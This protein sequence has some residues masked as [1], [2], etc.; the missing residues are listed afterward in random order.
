VY[1]TNPPKGRPDMTEDSISKTKTTPSRNAKS[2]STRAR[3][4]VKTDRRGAGE[5]EHPALDDALRYAKEGH[6]VFPLL[7]I[8]KVPAW[9][10]WIEKATTDP[11]IIRQW[12]E[13]YRR[14]YLGT[15][16][17]FGMVT[18]EGYVVI[19][20]DDL[21]AIP[22]LKAM[23]LSLPSTRTHATPR[24]GGGLQFIYKL[25][26]GYEIHSS[27]SVVVKGVDIKG[28]H[29][30]A[31]LPG[32]M[33]TKT[34][35]RYTIKNDV[36]VADLPEAWLKKLAERKRRKPTTT[37]PGNVPE[38]ERNDFLFR[39]GA[40]LR[41][42]GLD[43]DEIEAA[44]LVRNSQFDA[45]L[46]ERE[47]HRIAESDARYDTPA[48]IQAAL[49]SD[50]PK[51]MLPGNNR[52][53]AEVA[54]DF[55]KYLRDQPIF[56]R[57]R[58]AVMLDH[59][60]ATRISAQCFRSLVARH[61]VCLRQ[62]QMMNG[63]VTVTHSLSKDESEGVLAAP[64]FWEQLRPLTCVNTCK[65]PVRREN[66]NIELPPD[67]Y[68]EKT[69]MLTIVKV[70]FDERISFKRGRQAL[71]DLFGEFEFTSETS[72]AVAVAALMGRLNTRSSGRSQL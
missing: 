61:V 43:Q 67:G 49:N 53:L 21:A 45:P 51:V 24:E 46:A 18:G 50:L 58:E 6:R 35:G 23:G 40:K 5:R 34:H 33:H 16:C 28:W 38:G 9:K 48:D 4:P 27:A 25:P 68:D 63:L 57:N 60:D 71:D 59:H 14:K 3:E 13:E 64:Q 52:P 41:H 7:G 2:R 69:A 20:V 47:V 37:R 31:V 66:G 30:F 56:L 70:R 36:P 8:K 72:R 19:D 1:M 55:G 42:A 26:R 12:A 44:L 62:R 54:E 10:G 22:K 11:K 29:S 15:D 65:L 39:L 32:S 17:N